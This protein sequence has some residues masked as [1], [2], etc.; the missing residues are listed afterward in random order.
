[1]D[2][3]TGLLADVAVGLLAG[4][5]ATAVTGL[6]QEATDRAT[7]ERVRRREAAVRPGPSAQV[8]ARRIAAEAGAPLDD[9]EA[10]LA[11]RTLHYAIGSAWGLTYTLLRRR[12]VGP[13]PAGLAAG[14]SL[15][16]VVDEGIAPAL[17]FSAPNSSYPALTHLRGVVNHLVY[18][19]SVAVAAEVLHHLVRTADGTRSRERS[20]RV[21]PA[22]PLT[23]G[24]GAEP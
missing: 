7:P 17:G 10:T 23:A 9:A 24:P 3:S 12:G 19:A 6:A 18:G 20:R 15:S 1:M 2:R 21:T 22:S 11:G 8:A 16:L 5:A 14:L 4:L 13:V